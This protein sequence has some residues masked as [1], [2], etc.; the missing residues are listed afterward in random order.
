V[1]PN[2]QWAI[3][4]LL[5]GMAMPG[6]SFSEPQRDL[7]DLKGMGFSVLVTLTERPLPFDMVIR[8]GLAPFHIPVEDFEAPT[9]DQAEEFCRI[10]DRMKA[11]G[12]KVAVHCLAG[13]GRTGTMLAAYLI[14][15]DGIGAAE[16]IEKM[17]KIQPGYIQCEE[18][19]L[20]LHD[21]AEH[22]SSR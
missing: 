11:E 17:R 13:L 2:F 7:E 10:V 6:S 20:F 15:L 9:I 16:A 5:A 22:A 3:E 8:C 12:K 21:W 18:Q 1:P 4:G 19:E 14:H